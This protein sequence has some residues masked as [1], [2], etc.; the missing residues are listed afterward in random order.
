MLDLL[1]WVAAGTCIFAALMVALNAGAR[2]TGFGFL[3]FVASSLAWI[4][5]GWLQGQQSLVLQNV[6]LLLINLLGIWRWFGL[7]L[8]YAKG[9]LVAVRRSRAAGGTGA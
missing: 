9:A 6:V 1:N 7:K 4:A 3:V 5:S 8:R 2:I